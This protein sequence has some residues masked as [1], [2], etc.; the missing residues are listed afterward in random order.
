MRRMRDASH[1]HRIS[2]GE[3]TPVDA[4]CCNCY[5]TNNIACKRALL[6]DGGM[7]RCGLHA[8]TAFPRVAPFSAVPVP[9]AGQDEGMTTYSTTEDTNSATER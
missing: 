6:R 7:S 5:S 2:R 1:G 4:F 9:A 8:M 3:R